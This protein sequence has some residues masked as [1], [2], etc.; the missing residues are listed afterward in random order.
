MEPT[1]GHGLLA[2]KTVLVTAAAG[3]GIGF[4]TALRCAAEGATVAISDW[5]ERRLKEAARK[6]EEPPLAIAC[7]GTDQAQVDHLVDTVAANWAG[8]TC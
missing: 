1:A 6:F 2:G 4:S 3:T 5:H 8:S 7:D